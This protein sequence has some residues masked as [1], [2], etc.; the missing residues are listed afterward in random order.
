MIACSKL[1]LE[2]L[3]FHF[4]DIMA[5]SFLRG[6]SKKN[7]VINKQDLVRDELF[8]LNEHFRILNSRDKI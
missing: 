1:L 8:H 3:N 4:A 5:L 7:L 2:A 6:I